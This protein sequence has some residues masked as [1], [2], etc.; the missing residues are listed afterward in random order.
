MTRARKQPSENQEHYWALTKFLAPIDASI[1]GT[2]NTD[3]LAALEKALANQSR[4]SRKKLQARIVV[5]FLKRRYYLTINWGEDRRSL[6]R[7]E[8]AASNLLFISLT[9]ISLF[10]LA[11]IVFT[12]TYL[13]KSALG[14]DLFPNFSL[15]NLINMI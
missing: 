7:I 9:A 5:P 12:L 6:T 8:Q 1:T 2:F 14:I 11:T 4:R 15:G 10:L 13:L 3:Q